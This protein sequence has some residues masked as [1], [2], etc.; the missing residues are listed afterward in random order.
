MLWKLIVIVIHM[1]SVDVTITDFDS[2]FICEEAASWILNVST[3]H[4]ADIITSC[5][6][7]GD[8]PVSSQ[9]PV[10]NPNR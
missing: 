8:E 1:G 10:P 7:N 5:I 6:K 9:R 2:Q 3:P 4:D